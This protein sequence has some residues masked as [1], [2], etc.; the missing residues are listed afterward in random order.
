M[1]YTP[2]NIEDIGVEWILQ[3]PDG[4]DFRIPLETTTS[5]SVDKHLEQ[6][7]SDGDI[8]I[9]AGTVIEYPSVNDLPMSKLLGVIAGRLWTRIF[10]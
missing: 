5:E 8:A 6:I 2:S 4:S 10:G 9:P 3:R 7:Q 1:C